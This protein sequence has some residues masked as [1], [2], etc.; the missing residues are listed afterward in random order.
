MRN[1]VRLE[2]DTEEVAKPLLKDQYREDK[3]IF[4][5]LTKEQSSKLFGFEIKNNEKDELK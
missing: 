4:I 5:N 1:Q 2:E 3:P